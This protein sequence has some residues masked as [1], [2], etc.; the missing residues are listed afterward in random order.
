MRNGCLPTPCAGPGLK[1]IES[2]EVL[3]NE[4]NAGDAEVNLPVVIGTDT[5]KTAATSP[6]EETLKV[7][8]TDPMQDVHKEFTCCHKDNL[9]TVLNQNDI[10]KPPKGYHILDQKQDVVL[11]SKH[12]IGDHL[13]P[14]SKSGSMFLIVES[15]KSEKNHKKRHS[16]GSRKS[17][18]KHK[19]ISKRG[20]RAHDSETDAIFDENEGSDFSDDGN[21]VAEALPIR[22]TPPPGLCLAQFELGRTV[23]VGNFGRVK[24]AQHKDDKQKQPLAIKIIRKDV[25]LHMKQAL[26]VAQERTVLLMI[27]HPFIVKLLWTFQDE[28]RLFLVLEFVNGG[29]LF[30][31]LCMNGKLPNDEVRFF[32][33]EIVSALEYLHKKDIIYRDLKPENILMSSAGHMKITD[34]GFAKIVRKRTYTLCGTPQYIAPEIVLSKGHGKGVDWWALGILIFEMLVGFAPFDDDNP[35]VVYGMITNNN[36]KIDFPYAINKS[37]KSLIKSLLKRDRT[38]RLGTLRGG[39]EDIQLHAWFDGIEW[40]DVVNCQIPPPTI[41]KVIDEC[42]T[43]MFDDY[44]ESMEE[45]AEPCNDDLFA[46]F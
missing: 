11:S 4:Q 45:S 12:G 33:A 26:H 21:E 42:D 34:F 19:H 30:T 38:R 44:P 9:E 46:E 41:P 23:G 14:E 37:A 3:L 15:K 2:S 20:S 17:S 32:A 28:K 25:V 35:M 36:Q 16:K 27:D 29:E 43:S 5:E 24:F 13:S 6:R 18:T 8:F 1:S 7:I 10:S 39:G 31:H 40:D 22:P